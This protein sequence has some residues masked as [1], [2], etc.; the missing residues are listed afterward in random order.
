MRK[1]ALID[2]E[3]AFA[4]RERGKTHKEIADHFGVARQSVANILDGFGTAT[5]AR[6]LR[7]VAQ[8]AP[9]LVAVRNRERRSDAKLGVL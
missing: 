7:S 8:V 9:L 3:K 4:M 6:R 5:R 1:Y 2:K